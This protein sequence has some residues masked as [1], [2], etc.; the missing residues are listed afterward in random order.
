MSKKQPKHKKQSEYLKMIFEGISRADLAR[1]I[2]ISRTQISVWENG[3]QAVP[4]GRIYQVCE[5]VAKKHNK[6]E[7]KSLARLLSLNLIGAMKDD[8]VEAKIKRIEGNF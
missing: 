8:F 1:A 5:F 6:E 2:K 4:D 3:K 7:A